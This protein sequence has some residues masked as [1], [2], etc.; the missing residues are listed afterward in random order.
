MTARKAQPQ[1]QP[2]Q[3]QPTDFQ[4]DQQRPY[5]SESADFRTYVQQKRVAAQRASDDL[6]AEIDRLQ[7]EI[8]ARLTRRM[9]QQEILARCEAALTLEVPVTRQPPVI[10]RHEAESE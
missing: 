8:E 4:P 2:P 5:L 6:D 10:S 3:R 1:I 7:V 9:E